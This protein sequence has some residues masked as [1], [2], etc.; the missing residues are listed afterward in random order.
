[1]LR[2]QESGGARRPERSARRREILRS[3]ALALGSLLLCFLALE[4]AVRLFVDLREYRPVEVFDVEPER[5]I[6]F[7]PGSRRRYRTSEFEFSIA[8]NRFG[9]RD[10]EWS[11]E[12]LADPQNVLVIG[13]SLILGY[14]VEESWTVPSLLEQRAARAGRPREFLNFGIPAAGPLEYRE[15]LAEALRLGVAARTVVLGIFVGNDFT[16]GALEPRADRAARSRPPERRGLLSR[17]QLATFLRLRVA[18]SSRVVGWT[19]AASRWLGASVYDT[20]GSHIFLR[21]PTP[22]QAA[23]FRRILE[24]IGG[25]RAD[26]ERSGRRLLVA[27]FPNKIQVENGRELTNAIF[28]AER[29]DRAIL[30]YCAETGMDCLD[31]LPALRAGGER[32]GRPLYFPIDRHLDRAGNGI[33]ADAIFARLEAAGVLR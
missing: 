20:A 27:I 18:Q 24:L 14:G 31:L 5:G 8:A 25:I 30:D 26:C 22:E 21:Q 11:E 13:D 19:L 2:V 15:L 12:D 7:L 9:R 6:S 29:P 16:P 33:A 28:D 4:I 10:V 1:V 3:A 23:L 17:S 32:L